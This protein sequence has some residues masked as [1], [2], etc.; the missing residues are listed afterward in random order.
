MNN[1]SHQP[2]FSMIPQ[3]HLCQSCHCIIEENENLINEI[4]DL[5]NQISVLN[6][7]IFSQ[8]QQ[9]NQFNIDTKELEFLK[10]NLEHGHKCRKSF[11]NTSGF[12]VGTEGYKSCVLN[13]GRIGG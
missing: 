7:E 12:N 2:D 4:N 8:K 11:F 3:K 13:G 10:L 1:K 6:N 5:N 9:I